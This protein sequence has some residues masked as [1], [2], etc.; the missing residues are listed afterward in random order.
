MG[1]LNTFL[2]RGSSQIKM[3]P[4]WE[5]VILLAGFGAA[6]ESAQLLSHKCLMD[7][8]AFLW[9]IKQARPKD[10]AVQSKCCSLVKMICVKL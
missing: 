4:G 3:A 8:N 1:Y 10:Y 7:T 2:L 5:M 6:L 9:E